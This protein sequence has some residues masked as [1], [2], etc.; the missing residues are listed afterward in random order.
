MNAGGDNTQNY[1]RQ[2][3]QRLVRFIRQRYDKEIHQRF[4]ELG[5]QDDAWSDEFDWCANLWTDKP[6]K[7]N[8][9]N[10][11]FDPLS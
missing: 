1:R 3:I 5:V 9:V 7:E 2:E 4:I 10:Y 11:V 8:L 6:E